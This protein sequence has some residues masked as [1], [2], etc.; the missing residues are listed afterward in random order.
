M[1]SRNR[2]AH[3]DGA[4]RR[5]GSIDRLRRSALSCRAGRVRLH[6]ERRAVHARSG[7]GVRCKRSVSAAV[8]ARGWWTTSSSIPTAP[9]TP[10]LPPTSR[11]GCPRTRA[12]TAPATLDATPIQ[13]AVEALAGVAID[14]D[15]FEVRYAMVTSPASDLQPFQCMPHFDPA[16]LAGVVYLNAP[17]QCRGGTAFYRHRATG[18][19][20]APRPTDLDLVVLC[21]R[22]GVMGLDALLDLVMQPP[23]HPTGYIRDSNETWELNHLVPMRF[24]RLVLYDGRAFHSGYVEEGD[25]AS[26]HAGRRLT[27]NFFA[28]TKRT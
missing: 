12:L 27:L 9:A 2:T 3:L 10:R 1:A 28:T 25:F 13:D 23:A 22:A 7:I 15:R 16:D 17:A 24:N 20:A 19:E 6:P 8:P 4:L 26:D 18:L 11:R 21:M 5:G 14:R